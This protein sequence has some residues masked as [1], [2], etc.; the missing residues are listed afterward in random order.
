MACG[1]VCRFGC[2]SLE[3]PTLGSVVYFVDSLER[4]GCDL[5]L[6][7]VLKMLHGGTSYQVRVHGGLSAPFVLERGLR[8][9][10][11]SSPVLLTSIMLRL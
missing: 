1:M 2:P 7:K 8:E 10:C 11:P 9:G 4:W 5:S 6:L 3:K